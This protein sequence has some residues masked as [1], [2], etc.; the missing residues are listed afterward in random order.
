VNRRILLRS[1]ARLAQDRGVSFQ[2]ERST[3]PHDV[4]RWGDHVI[5]IPRHREVNERLA[6]SIL[7]EVHKR[8][9]ERE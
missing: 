7:R 2:F 9:E 3:G 4:Y 1:L 8:A 6:R 5:A